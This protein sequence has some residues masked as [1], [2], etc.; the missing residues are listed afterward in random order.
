MP[1]LPARIQKQ[2]KKTL[3]FVFPETEIFKI[4]NKQSLTER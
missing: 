2:E 3:S 4:E 1:N